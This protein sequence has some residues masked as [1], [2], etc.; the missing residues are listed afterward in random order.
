MSN[1]DKSK[2]LADRIIEIFEEGIFLSDEVI[3]YI[4]STFSNPSIEELEDILQDDTNC[5][6][7]SLI[8]LLFFPDKQLQYQLEELLENG[9]FEEE[10]EKEVLD[11]L[12]RNPLELEFHFPEDRGSFSLGITKTT[13]HLTY[14]R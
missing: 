6:K 2:L 13:A 4:D 3:Q 5:E 1:Y 14:N 10:D 7:D 11:H 9:A 12:C 8:E